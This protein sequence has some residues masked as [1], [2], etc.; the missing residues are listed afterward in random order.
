MEYQFQTG[1]L[2]LLIAAVVAMLTRRLKLPYSVGLVVAGILHAVL[3]FAPNIELTKRPHFYCIASPAS[4]RRSVLHRLESIAPGL[5]CGC[6]TGD[7]W[8]H[9]RIAGTARALWV[10]AK[11]SSM[12]VR[13]ALASSWRVPSAN[14]LQ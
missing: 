12:P 3:P 14:E 2:L 13:S 4:L 5:F 9:Y 1:T 10:F 11:I 6:C 8:S 7:T